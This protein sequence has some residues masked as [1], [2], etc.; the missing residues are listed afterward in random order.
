MSMP[1][2]LKRALIAQGKLDSDGYSRRAK[3][4]FCRQC[5]APTIRGLDDDRIALEVDLDV[6][7]L[8]NADELTAVLAGRG[9]HRVRWRGDRYEIDPRRG[10]IEISGTPAD[11]A[12]DVHAEHLC[13]GVLGTLA[14]D[15]PS[16]VVPTGPT[17]DPGF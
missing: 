17:T 1:E 14:P 3:V 5:G 16:R 10:P 9:T 15:R 8:D 2:W 12:H 6:T 11:R 4:I 13:G 7:C